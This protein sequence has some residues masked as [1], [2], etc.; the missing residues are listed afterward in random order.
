M[1]RQGKA[2]P[3]I[4]CEVQAQMELARATTPA[5][6][7]R[8]RQATTAVS[9]QAKAYPLRRRRLRPSS[10][11]CARATTHACRRQRQRL[12]DDGCRVGGVYF[13]KHPKLQP[14]GDNVCV[15]ATTSMSRR[16][17]LDRFSRHWHFLVLW[18][19]KQNFSIISFENY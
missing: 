5:V 1:R 4:P 15:W 14:L 8:H 18:Q 11:A 3:F 12:C 19:S 16:R 10:N 13:H 9:A 6:A 2:G 17:R 7:R